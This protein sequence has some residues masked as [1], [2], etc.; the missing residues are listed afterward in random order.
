MA[1]PSFD[2]IL[3]PSDGRHP[4]LVKLVTTPVVHDSESIV[5]AR[6][7]LPHPEIY[8]DYI[9]EAPGRRAWGYQVRSIGI[10][11]ASQD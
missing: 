8:M 6:P 11:S 7:S 4:C 2:A 10:Q 1:Q 3:I 9:A 5:I